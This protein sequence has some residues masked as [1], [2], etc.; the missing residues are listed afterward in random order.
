MMRHFKRHVNDVVFNS[1][2]L[3]IRFT[4]SVA[5]LIIGAGLAFPSDVFQESM[6]VSVGSGINSLS[7]M[8]QIAPDWAWAICFLTQGGMTMFSLLANY[9]NKW[10]VWLDAAFGVTLWTLSVGACYIAYWG[11]FYQVM[12]NYSPAV[13]GGN[14]SFVAASWWVFVRYHSGADVEQNRHRKGRRATDR[15]P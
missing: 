4:L 3:A 13:M 12:E 2:M 10:L 11:G 15:M 6:Q 9:Q 8:G 5:A 7:P 1:D 14:L